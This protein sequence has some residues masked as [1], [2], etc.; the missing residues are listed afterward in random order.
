VSYLTVEDLRCG[1]F[2][3]HALIAIIALVRFSF[4]LPEPVAG[5]AL[6]THVQAI[7]RCLATGRTWG[8]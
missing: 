4:P 2:V 1:A 7:L 6:L 8:V 5:Q 3:T